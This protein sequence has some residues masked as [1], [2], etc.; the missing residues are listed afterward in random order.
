[1]QKFHPLYAINRPAYSQQDFDEEFNRKKINYPLKDKVKEAFKY[2]NVFTY[3]MLSLTVS[4]FCF[5]NLIQ[6]YFCL[7]FL[8]MMQVLEW[9]TKTCSLQTRSSSQ[10]ASKIQL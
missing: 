3:I 2:V 7:T 4:I 10:L 1:M 9:A 5:V 6:L 8:S